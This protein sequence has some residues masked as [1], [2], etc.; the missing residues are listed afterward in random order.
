MIPFLSADS[1]R[2]SFIVTFTTEGSVSLRLSA[3][4]L[5]KR[6]GLLF[7]RALAVP[8]LAQEQHGS[9]TLHPLL[10][11]RGIQRRKLFCVFNV[12]VKVISAMDRSRQSWM[13]YFHY[14]FQLPIWERF[15]HFLKI[16]STSIHQLVKFFQ[17]VVIYP[18]PLLFSSQNPI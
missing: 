11:L 15:F 5:Q 17:Q 9:E 4:T 3:P 16:F 2:A 18:L 13:S 1:L 12:A 6:S 14:V 8:A 10:S 7:C